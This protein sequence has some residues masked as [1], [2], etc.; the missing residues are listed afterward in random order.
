[1]TGQ[2]YY[3]EGLHIESPPL[4]YIGKYGGTNPMEHR[5]PRKAD[6]H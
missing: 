1:M 3:L 6:S 2:G 4:K 5:P